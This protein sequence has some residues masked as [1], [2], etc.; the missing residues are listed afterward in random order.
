MLT[1]TFP[2]AVP[3]R[4]Y[5]IEETC[6]LLGTSRKSLRKWTNAQLIHAKMHPAEA[7]LFYEGEEIN[8]FWNQTI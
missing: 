3:D 4:R 7:R 1:R 8:R 5:S 6:E 2:N